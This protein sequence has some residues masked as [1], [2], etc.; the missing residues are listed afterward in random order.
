MTRTISHIHRKL[1]TEGWQF[2][3][4]HRRQGKITDTNN[5]M[6]DTPTNMKTTVDFSLTTFATPSGQFSVF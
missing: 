3:I 5:L 1:Q 2:C 6:V 4:F